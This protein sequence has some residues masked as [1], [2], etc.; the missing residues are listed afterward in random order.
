MRTSD[1]SARGDGR[2][3]RVFD[4]RLGRQLALKILR[5]DAADHTD[6]M[7][8]FSRSADDGP[9]GTSRIIPIH[10]PNPARRTGGFTMKEVTGQT[11]G[12]V[13]AEVHA[14][15]RG[16]WQPDASGWTPRRPV[17]ALRHV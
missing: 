8:R 14:A 1:S 5:E 12:A 17:E 2:G 10:I 9:V 3:P 11:F 13:I 6:R 7:V 16:Q 15:S 4:R